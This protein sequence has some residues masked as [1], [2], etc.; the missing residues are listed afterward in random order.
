MLLRYKPFHEVLYGRDTRLLTHS[1]LQDQYFEKCR[2]IV[3]L[4]DPD[5][6]EDDKLRQFNE[7][8]EPVVLE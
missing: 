6:L 1:Q 7:T 5:A 4:S 2:E 8:I 3:A